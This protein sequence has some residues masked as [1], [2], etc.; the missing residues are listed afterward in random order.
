[1]ARGRGWGAG[2]LETGV[3]FTTRTGE[4]FEALSAE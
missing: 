2:G 1:L 4:Q 3:G